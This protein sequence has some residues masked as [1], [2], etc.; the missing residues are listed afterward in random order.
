MPPVP[1]EACY[2][3]PLGLRYDP[4]A[5]EVF[6]VIDDRRR[7]SDAGIAFFEKRVRARVASVERV[8]DDLPDDPR[9]RLFR[10]RKAP[11]VAEAPR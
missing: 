1:P 11:M 4:S 8:V 2:Y 9:W 5:P 10:V 3:L 7:A 6:V